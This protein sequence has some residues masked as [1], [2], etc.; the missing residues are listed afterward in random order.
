MAGM[1]SGESRVYSATRASSVGSSRIVSIGCD[2]RCSLIQPIESSA[3]LAVHT[4]LKQDAVHTV[5]K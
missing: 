1:R 4:V 5:L 2:T 3:V